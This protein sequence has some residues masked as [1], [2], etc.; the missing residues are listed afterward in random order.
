MSKDYR[1]PKTWLGSEDENVLK[2]LSE[3]MGTVAEL[4]TICAS[5]THSTSPAPNEAGDFSGKAS[6]AAAQK[7]RLDPITK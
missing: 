6:A 4:A 5:H 7:A 3:L 2:L 1:S